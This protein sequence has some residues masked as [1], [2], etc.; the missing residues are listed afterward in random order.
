[1]DLDLSPEQELLVRAAR[2][3]LSRSCPTARVR[4]IEASPAGFDAELWRRMAELGWLGIGLPEELG[5]AGQTFLETALLAEEMGRTLLPSPFIPTVAV[6]ARLVEALGSAEQRRRWLPLIARGGTIATLALIEPGWRDEWQ[7]VEAHAVLDGDSIRL[8]GRKCWVP[9]ADS[10]DLT[11][12]AVRL[13]SAGLTLLALDR[14]VAGRSCSRLDTF[15][16]E[17]LFEVDFDLAVPAT[18]LLGKPGDVESELERARLRAMIA[19]L[20]YA[21]GASERVLEMTVEYAKTRNQ[22]GRPIGSFQA[23]A[24]RCVDMRSDIDALRHLVHQAA[25]NLSRGHGGGLEAAAAKA[26][27]NEALR[28]I[29]VNAHQVH[30]AIGFSM[31]HDLQL[32]TR[33]AKAVELQWGST[34]F[35]L[36]RVAARMGL[37]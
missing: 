30:G 1:M 24:H 26:W 6:A 34:G 28:R 15:G 20:A 3:F 21:T 8:R 35:H 11:I 10:A 9:F 16:G 27:G 18:A 4:A 17:P 23:V 7:P 25:W 19:S 31:E 13:E 14:Y 2:S 22:F 29:Q 33:R 5:G 32:F 36:E 12:V 37:G